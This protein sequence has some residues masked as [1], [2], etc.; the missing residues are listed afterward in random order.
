VAVLGKDNRR[1]PADI[2]A[3]PV[4]QKVVVDTVRPEVRV[5]TADRRGDEVTVRWQ[6]LEEHPDLATLKLEYRTADGPGA[7]WMPA[8]VA[9]PQSG[10]ARFRAAD[11]VPLA[12]RMQLRDLAGNPGRWV[13]SPVTSGS[14]GGATAGLPPLPPGG[15]APAL[16][17]PPPL[18]PVGDGGG[19]APTPPGGGTQ[20]VSMVGS[21]GRKDNTT[22][23]GAPVVA[24]AGGGGPGV[25][26]PALPRAVSGTQPPLQMVNRRQ[27]TLDYEVAKFGPSGVGSVELYVT[28]DDG[29]TWQRSGGEENLT[30]PAPGDAK[31]LPSSLKRSLTVDLPG[32]GLYGFYLVVKSGAGLGKPPPQKGDA[33]QMRIEVDTRAPEARLFRPEPDPARRDALVLRWTAA[34]PNL[35]PTPVLLQWSAQKN[36]TWET[37]GGAEQANAGQYVWQVPTNVPPHVYL[38]LLVRDTAG[39]EAV[40][41]T[42]EPVLIDLHEPEVQSLRLGGG[43]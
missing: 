37:I 23:P 17:P 21:G 3:A 42:T 26:A 39:N 38:R 10:Q 4:G 25:G 40:A 35:G 30:A 9:N 27:I 29:R 41:E 12:V 5:V 16:V 11:G 19:W 18:P 43:K 34:D 8:S 28:R 31:G 2:Y 32:D 36:G 6:V 22:E 1:D 15:V 20:P 13:E 33:P 14:G 24:A 7:L